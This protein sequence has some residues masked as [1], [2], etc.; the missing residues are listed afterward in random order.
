MSLPSQPLPI[1][2]DK[3]TIVEIDS[4]EAFFAN[5]KSGRTRAFLG[6]ILQH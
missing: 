6:Q 3:G 5:P 4:F 2:M 1:F